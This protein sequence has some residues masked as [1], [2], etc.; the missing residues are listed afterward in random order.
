MPDAPIRHETVTVERRVPIYRKTC[1]ACGVEFEAPTQRVYCSTACRMR[2]Q[3]RSWN[4]DHPKATTSATQTCL[5]CATEFPRYKNQRFCSPACAATGHASPGE[6][7]WD[8]P[9]VAT[10]GA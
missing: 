7:I 8:D 5:V 3:S 10:S 2:Q 1:P 9:A 6:S 4:A